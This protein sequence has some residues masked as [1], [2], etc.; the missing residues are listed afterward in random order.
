MTFRDLPGPTRTYQDLPGPTVRLPW[1][2]V[3][4][5]PCVPMLN[6]RQ[7]HCSS[8]ACGRYA[9]LAFNFRISIFEF[10]FSCRLRVAG[11]GKEHA[12]NDAVVWWFWGLTV[13]GQMEEV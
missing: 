5:V 8:E 4:F 12:G 7:W 9:E 11:A 13:R 10:R 6:S 3:T 1:V 2:T